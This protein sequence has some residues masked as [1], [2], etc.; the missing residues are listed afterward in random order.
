[1]IYRRATIWDAESITKLWDKMH[2]ETDVNE[3]LRE[4]YNNKESMFIHM[5]T[6]IKLDNWVVIVVEDEGKIAGFIMGFVRQPDYNPCHIIGT[7]EAMYVVPEYRHNGIHKELTNRI[8]NVARTKGATQFELIG[9]YSPSLIKFWD[10][11]GFEPVQIVYRYKE[12][13]HGRKKS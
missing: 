2:D 7:C 4:E 1:M 12:E 6:R 8:I 13:N 9:T 10:H 11:M 5:V 3:A